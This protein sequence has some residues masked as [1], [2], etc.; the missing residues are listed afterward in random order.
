VGNGGGSGGTNGSGQNLS[1]SQQQLNQ[2]SSSQSVNVV[3]GTGG[4]QQAIAAAAGPLPEGWEQAMTPEG[5]VYFINHQ[6]RTT[7]WFDPRLRKCC[8]Y[9]LYG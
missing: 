1:G 9:F 2:S 5:E 6:T 8:Y 7:S 4:P 3:P